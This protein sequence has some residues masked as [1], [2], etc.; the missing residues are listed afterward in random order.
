VWQIWNWYQIDER[1]VETEVAETVSGVPQRDLRM[2]DDI[3]NRTA[4]QGLTIRWPFVVVVVIVVVLDE[5]DG[6]RAIR[7]REGRAA[8]RPGDED[9]SRRQTER[10][11][12]VVVV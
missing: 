3:A 4:S 1:H 12:E 7:R 6:R 9:Q 5:F 8:Q 2:S 11:S 10:H